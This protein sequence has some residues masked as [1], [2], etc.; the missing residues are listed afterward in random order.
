MKFLLL[1]LLF[2]FPLTA[3]TEPVG[4]ACDRVREKALK[5]A[6]DDLAAQIEVQV[7]SE[8]YSQMSSYGEG[9]TRHLTRTETDLPIY[10]YISERRGECVKVF[11]DM[12]KAPNA[13]IGRAGELA[14]E[15]NSLTKPSNSPDRVKTANYIKALSIY[16]EF[17]RI[18]TVARF[19]DLKILP[20]DKSIGEIEAEI[21]ALQESSDDIEQIAFNIKSA[22]ARKSYY[23]YPPV[24]TGTNAVTPFGVSLAKLISADNISAD[25]ARYLLD[26]EFDPSHENF[27]IICMLKD[28]LGKPIETAVSS[29]NRKVCEKIS[30]EADSAYKKIFAMRQFH[31]NQPSNSGGVLQEVWKG[32]LRGFFYTDK[33]LF[34]GEPIYLKSGDLLRLYARFSDNVSA[35]VLV[36]AEDGGAFLLPLSENSPVK[37]AVA[38][39]ETELARVKVESPYGTEILYLLGVYGNIE[40]YLPKYSYNT[41]SGIY[42]INGSAGRILADFRRA[43]KDTPFYEGSLIIY[44]E[45]GS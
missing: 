9:F 45:V 16:K 27:L 18:A 24:L 29:A 22:L 43:V 39:F 13:Y 21:A 32:T 7:F 17:G 5:Y 28:R 25:S 44:S 1:L 20:P 34:R 31:G 11:F 26:C 41:L 12:K 14:K 10:A 40:D 38:G 42:D 19:L 33:T 15:V 2:F 4:E 23:V 6:L 36:A 3:F 8:L 37:K 35:V 30:C